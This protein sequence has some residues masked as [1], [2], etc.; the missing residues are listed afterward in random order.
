MHNY[1]IGN[2]THKNGGEKMKQKPSENRKYLQYSSFP[3]NGI[4]TIC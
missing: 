4:M 3:M 2:D 1:R